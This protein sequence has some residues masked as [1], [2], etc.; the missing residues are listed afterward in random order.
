MKSDNKK[1]ECLC[2]E[3]KVKNRDSKRSNDTKGTTYIYK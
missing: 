2:F 1:G 3:E